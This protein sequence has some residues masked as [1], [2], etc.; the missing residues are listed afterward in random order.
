[1]C[2]AAPSIRVN[3]GRPALLPDEQVEL[4]FPL[5]SPLSTKHDNAWTNWRAKG[6]CRLCFWDLDRGQR[7]SMCH[8]GVGDLELPR[9]G[10]RALT[11]F[12]SSGKC[13][14]SE[15]SARTDRFLVTWLLYHSL[16]QNIRVTLQI[17]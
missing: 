9:T 10:H 2:A 11:P 8:V 15:P 3:Q 5:V 4:M 17:V 1:M 7:L 13:R 16:L 6:Q 12:L 14:F